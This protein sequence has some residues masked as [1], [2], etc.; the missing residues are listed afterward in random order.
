MLFMR[1]KRDY[2]V[3]GQLV[4]FGIRM[5]ATSVNRGRFSEPED[6]LFSE[7]G[8]YNGLGVVEFPVSDVPK[9]ISQANGPT[10]VFF[11][12]HVPLET[13]TEINYA[14]SEICSAHQNAPDRFREPSKT[15][16]REFKA[17]LCK[18]IRRDRIKIE[19]VL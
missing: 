8:K 14:H 6:V 11:M 4:H 2:F 1:Y 12:E 16:E 15:V 9:Q 19:A 7:D 5:P 17:R 18:R 10:Y 3:D 13:T